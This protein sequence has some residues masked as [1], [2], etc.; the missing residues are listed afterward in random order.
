MSSNE[1]L[2][3]T[4]CWKVRRETLPSTLFL[5]RLRPSPRM[6]WG[7][8]ADSVYVEL[9][10]VSHDIMA[11]SP[12]CVPLLTD[13][14]G[15]ECDFVESIPESLFCPVCLLPFRDPHLLDCCGVKLCATCTGRIDAAGS[16]CPQCRQRFAHILDQNTRRQVLNMK[17]RCSR[18]KDGCEWE[19]ELRHLDKHERKDCGW[20]IEQCRQC[21]G[22]VLRCLQVEH[23]RKECP[24]R[25]VDV[26]LENLMHKI[27]MKLIFEKEL[28]MR[29]MAAVR[30]ELTNA[31]QKEREGH[32]MELAALKDNF[33]KALSEERQS[34]KRELD[35]KEKA[36]A[37]QVQQME[38]L[39]TRKLAENKKEY[40]EKLK[41]LE[42]SLQRKLRADTEQ[43]LLKLRKEVLE[44]VIPQCVMVKEIRG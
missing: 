24:Q 41:Q 28:H 44:E 25:P 6:G 29:E 35:E 7:A 38:Q 13:T 17:V 32:K 10:H 33:T 21:G 2:T 9:S 22:R 4:N 11:Q 42:L 26:K 18:K 1:R 39:M 16:P 8:A 43:Q 12:E 30:E 3:A 40:A 15:Y 20:I 37:A 14:G 19:G 31:L 23:E 27:E 5:L 36:H 34:H